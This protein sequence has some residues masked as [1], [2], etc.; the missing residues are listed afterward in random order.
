MIHTLLDAA[1]FILEGQ[2]EPQSPYWLASQMLEGKLWRASEHDVRAALEQDI[3]ER[4]DGSRF[5]KA[6]DVEYA[7]R[8]WIKDIADR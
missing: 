8:S 3:A 6:D 7:L 1:V 5:V 4:G 2:G